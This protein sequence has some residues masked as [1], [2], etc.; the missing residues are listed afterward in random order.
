[1]DYK[2]QSRKDKIQMAKRS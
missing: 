2:G 1:M